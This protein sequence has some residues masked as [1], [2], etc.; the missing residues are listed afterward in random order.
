MRLEV[1]S[2][3]LSRQNLAERAASL[4][5]QGVRNSTLAGTVKRRSDGA[6]AGAVQP[7]LIPNGN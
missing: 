2:V 7:G 3:S 6:A 4:A 1:D 5:V